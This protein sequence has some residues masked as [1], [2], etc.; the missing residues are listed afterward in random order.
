[1]MLRTAEAIQNSLE[2]V[3]H[4]HQP[5]VFVACTSQVKQFLAHGGGEILGG[6][7]DSES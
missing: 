1:M 5:K 4:E 6:V 2:T 3:L 7:E